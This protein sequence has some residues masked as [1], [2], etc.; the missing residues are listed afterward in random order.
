MV[1]LSFIFTNPPEDNSLHDQATPRIYSACLL[2]GVGPVVPK[3]IAHDHLSLTA[4]GEGTFNS[5]C[6]LD[7]LQQ[8]H[9]I[10]TSPRREKTTGTTAV[11]LFTR[12]PACR[13]ASLLARP[14]RHQRYHHRRH[15]YHHHP[16]LRQPPLLHPPDPR[17][18]VGL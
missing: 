9:S 8:Y 7:Y 2:L 1:S 10:T 6:T 13:R 18:L 3:P 14:R 17:R 15:H 11:L 4:V 16:Y 5:Y 12:R